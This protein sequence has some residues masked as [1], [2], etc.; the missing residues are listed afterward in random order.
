MLFDCKYWISIL[1]SHTTV[2]RLVITKPFKSKLNSTT[3]YVHRIFLKQCLLHGFHNIS[4]LINEI[5]LIVF[6]NI[7]RNE[8]QLHVRSLCGGSS[9][10]SPLL[11]ISTVVCVCWSC[12]LSLVIFAI[13][14]LFRCCWSGSFARAVSFGL[15]WLSCVAGS[16]TFNGSTLLLL[17]VWPKTSMLL[18]VDPFLDLMVAFVDNLTSEFPLAEIAD[19]TENVKYCS[20]CQ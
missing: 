15:S 14:P 2:T 20:S 16:L 6:T 19:Q 7:P 5:H 8:K 13:D 12:I 17:A 1:E 18:L 4:V 3:K 9:K 11:N 10:L